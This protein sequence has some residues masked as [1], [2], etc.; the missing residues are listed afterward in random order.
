LGADAKRP[1]ADLAQCTLNQTEYGM[2][3]I[4][5]VDRE[6]PIRSAAHLVHGI[7]R[8]IDGQAFATFTELSDQITALGLEGPF[9]SVLLSSCHFGLLL[10]HHP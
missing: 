4:D 5:A 9:E 3:S 10:C 1:V 7:A 6:I 2:H 8:G